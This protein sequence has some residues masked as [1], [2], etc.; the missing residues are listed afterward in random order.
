MFRFKRLRLNFGTLPPADAF[1]LDGV[2]ETARDE[3]SVTLEIRENLNG[4]LST[5]VAYN[6]LDMDTV[7]VTL[8]EV[9]L[10]YYGG[11]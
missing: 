4:V 11:D 2:T 6:V 1:A 8:E 5:A 9:F 10:A 7:P 3:Q